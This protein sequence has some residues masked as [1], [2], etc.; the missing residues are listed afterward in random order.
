MPPRYIWAPSEIPPK[1]KLQR[2]EKER[3]VAEAEKFIAE[4]YRHEFIKPAPKN[5]QFNHIVDF[6]ADF[7]GSYLRF[8]AKYACPGPRALSPSFEHPFARLGCFG[9][10]RWNLGRAGTT[11]SGSVS[12]ASF[13]HSQSVL[14]PCART[15]G[16]ISECHASYG[17]LRSVLQRTVLVD[18]QAAPIGSFFQ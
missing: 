14:S 11:T 4:F 1:C 12:S 15:H 18:L 8:Y 13:R 2:L 7:S 9:R 3:C 10:D 17:P 6:R 16:S 5:Y